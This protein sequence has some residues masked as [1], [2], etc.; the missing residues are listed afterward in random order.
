MCFH[1]FLLSH[2]E[3]N[4]CEISDDKIAVCRKTVGLRSG[5]LSDLNSVLKTFQFQEMPHESVRFRNRTNGLM[6]K[7]VLWEC[8][9]YWFCNRGED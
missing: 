6:Q 4:C 8:F 3:K 2:N 9:F 5:N 7:V 1:P